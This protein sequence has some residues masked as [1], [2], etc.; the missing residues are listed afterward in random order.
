MY[1]AVI[2]NDDRMDYV[3]CRLYSLGCEVSRSLSKSFNKCIVILPP[4]VGIEKLDI[5]KPYFSN[6]SVIY[7]GSISDEFIENVP[8]DINIIDYLSFEF[9]IKE[10]AILTAK[11]I[12]KQAL[13]H[14]GNMNELNILVTG[15]GYCG[16]A[17]SLELLNKCANITIAVRNNK[18]KNEIESSGYKFL[19]IKEL[20][21]GYNSYDC[22]FNTVP[23]KIIDKEVIDH[24]NKSIMM[25]D[26][27][28]KPGGIDFEYCKEKE[29]FAILSLGIPGKEYPQD[30][31]YI[32]GDACYNHYNN[33]YN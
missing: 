27:A 32:I 19:N 3:A 16:K 29:I 24:F 4:P 10:N 20:S 17:I 22:L 26:I 21:S 8:S 5:L 30:A 7:G 13:N 23:S 11:G 14:I 25:F 31:G 18:L 6:I 15:Y 33:H 2:G 28:S 1:F 12:I 9:V